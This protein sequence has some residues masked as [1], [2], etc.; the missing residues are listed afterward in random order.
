MREPPA[1]VFPLICVECGNVSGADDD[2]ILGV[3]VI[4]SEEGGASRAPS[5]ETRPTR[6]RAR[7]RREVNPHTF[8]A[9]VGPS[10]LRDEPLGPLT[11]RP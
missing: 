2:T 11:A 8:S 3:V 4:N 6:V 7:V 10:A 9:G 5:S 1:A